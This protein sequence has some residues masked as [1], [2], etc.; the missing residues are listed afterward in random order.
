MMISFSGLDGAG[1]STQI[2]LLKSRLERD[3]AKVRVIWA[4]GGYT[5]GFEFI[6]NSIRLIFK[7]SLPL[8]GKSAERQAVINN[9][10]VRG[11]WL[12]ISILDLMLIWGIYARVLRILGFIVIFDRYTKDTLLDFRY[13][14]PESNVESGY[15]WRSLVRFCPQPDDS[16]LF[17]VPVKTSIERSL[18]KK[19]PFSDDAE[20]LQWR[21]SAYMDKNIFPKEEHFRIDGQLD[22]VTI[23]E[24]VHSKIL[25]SLRRKVIIC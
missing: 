6:K 21:F 11:I 5:P 8:S 22:I 2:D 1:K 12:A 16:L 19:E 18:A 24:D 10:T 17:W 15:L 23:A 20:T 7:K 9:P 13:N 4:R 25:P 3:G 14:F